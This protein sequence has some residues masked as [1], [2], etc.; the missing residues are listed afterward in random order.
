MFTLDDFRKQ[1]SQMARLGPLQ[2]VMD[3]IP[4]MGAQ[5]EM[6][7]DVDPAQGMKRLFG[8]IDSMT[9]AERRMPNLIDVNR[10][11]RISSGAGVELLEVSELLEQFDVMT[12]MM[13]KMDMKGRPN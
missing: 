5:S 2:K 9:P 8:I 4:G 11:R 12:R 13:T 6:M 10:R 1:L 3:M 7:G